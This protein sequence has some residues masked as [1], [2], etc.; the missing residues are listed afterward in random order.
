MQAAA[1]S[2]AKEA[3]NPPCILWMFDAQNVNILSDPEGGGA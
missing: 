1:Q 3:D 2:T